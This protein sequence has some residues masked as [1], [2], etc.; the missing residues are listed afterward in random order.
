MAKDC[1]R[2]DSRQRGPGISMAGLHVPRWGRCL[3]G[4]RALGWAQ[5][6]SKGQDRRFAHLI[7]ALQQARVCSAA[8]NAAGR[9]RV[10]AAALGP[11]SKGHPDLAEENN[12]GGGRRH[13]R[14]IFFPKPETR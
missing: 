10:G 12:G 14:R 7:R 2:Q 4:A 13:E 1:R 11:D 6:D 8:V 3:N 9:F 5:A